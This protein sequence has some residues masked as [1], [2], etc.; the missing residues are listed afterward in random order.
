MITGVADTDAAA[1]TDTVALPEGVI[2]GLTDGDALLLV[3]GL[4]DPDTLPLAEEVGRLLADPDT[5]PDT[6]TDGV[7][8]GE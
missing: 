3:E 7:A 2:D 4:T 6:V 5:L 8:D 1:V